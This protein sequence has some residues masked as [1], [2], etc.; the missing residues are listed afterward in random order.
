MQET[1][2]LKTTPLASDHIRRNALMAPFAGWSMPIRYEGI[3][4]ETLYTRRAVSCFDICHMGE[5][6]IK[7][8][9]KKSGLDH[10]VSARIDNLAVGSCRYSSLLNKSGGIIDDL[11]IYRK[12]A[13]SWMI[14]VNAGTIEKDAAHFIHHLSKDSSFSNLSETTGKIDLQGPLARDIIKT[15]AP[16]AAQ[17]D[18]YTFI[19]TD[20]LGEKTIISRTGYTGELGYEI[21]FPIGKISLTWEMLL[22]DNRV[23]PAGLGA[24]DILRLEMGYSLYGQDIDETVTPLEAGL[25]KFIDFDKDFIGRPALPKPDKAASGRTRLFVSSQSRRSPRHNQKI[26]LGDQEIGIITSGTFSPHLD[27]GIGMGFANAPLKI[28]TPI[29]IG[30]E[31]SAFDAIVTDKPFVKKTSLKN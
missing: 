21:Y 14:V 26:T 23:K 4:A 17:L 28:G 3:I 22:K 13:D 25:V 9:C 8:D 19:E 24:R 11:I 18:Y 12:A 16:K 2:A 7:G 15:I 20:W 29:R 10:L 6:L 27:L 31:N 1:A 30:E 5:F